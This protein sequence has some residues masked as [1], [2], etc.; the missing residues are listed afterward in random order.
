MSGE[1]DQVLKM[2]PLATLPL[3]TGVEGEDGP[4]ALGARGAA[5]G[6]QQGLDRFE[7]EG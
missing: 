2:A 6:G 1:R 5:C 3:L 4:D 7:E